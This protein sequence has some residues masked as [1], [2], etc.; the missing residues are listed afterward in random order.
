MRTPGQKTKNPGLFRDP[1]S[2]HTR[3]PGV[4]SM[5]ICSA[6][7][8]EQRNRRPSHLVGPAFDRMN[9][10]AMARAT[11]AVKNQSIGRAPRL[12][13]FSWP[14]GLLRRRDKAPAVPEAQV[15]WLGIRAILWHRTAYF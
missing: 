11:A 15:P 3:H 10:E 4:P 5:S 6:E 2:R 12:A 13:F 9:K 1:G 7:Q 8:V 14:F